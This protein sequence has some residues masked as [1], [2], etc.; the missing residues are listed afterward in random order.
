M[1]GGERINL[2]E[3]LRIFY[4]IFL[5]YRLPKSDTCPQAVYDQLMMPCWEYEKER[6]PTFTLILK[7][8]DSIASEFGEPI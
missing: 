4:L 2:W 5:F 8:I 6:R 7:T 1:E 3:S